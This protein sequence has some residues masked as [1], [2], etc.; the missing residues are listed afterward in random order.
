M[1]ISIFSTVYLFKFFNLNTFSTI[2]S[3][4][5]HHIHLKKYFIDIIL[6]KFLQKVRVCQVFKVYFISINELFFQF[7]S[8]IK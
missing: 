6:L 2:S 1:K 5:D 7:D 4:P 8:Q 3:L